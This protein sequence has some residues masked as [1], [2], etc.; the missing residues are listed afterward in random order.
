MTDH[1]LLILRA[2]SRLVPPVER[3]V[4]YSRLWLTRRVVCKHLIE[5]E[6]QE[7]VRIPRRQGPVYLTV[8]GQTMI[9]RLEVLRF[10]AQ[11]QPM[12]RVDLAK[13]LGMSLQQLKY[14]IGQLEDDDLVTLG[15]NRRVCWLT[16]KGKELING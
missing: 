13:K 7:L 4:L 10:I 11:H 14:I 2:L 16:V 3:E 12:L 5:L 8:K 15:A 1:S 9:D 6:R